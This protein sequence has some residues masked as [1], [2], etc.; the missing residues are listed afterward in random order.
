MVLDNTLMMGY[1][2]LGSSQFSGPP[3][4]F[5]KFSLATW[6]KM[7]VAFQLRTDL[8]TIIV[9]ILLNTYNFTQGTYTLSTPGSLTFTTTDKILIGGNSQSFLGEFASFRVI[10]P[11]S[12]PLPCKGFTLV[13]SK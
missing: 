9:D 5:P 4:V 8:Q 6:H 12:M 11:G 2:V 1:T 10:S 3:G 13:S 7:T